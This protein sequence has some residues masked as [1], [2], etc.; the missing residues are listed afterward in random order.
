MRAHL[1]LR[2]TTL[3]GATVAE[4]RA[5]NSVMRGGAELVANL[6]AGK[7]TPITHMVVGTN[8]E[9]EGDQFSTIA[10]ANA[11]VGGEPALTGGTEAPIPP[12]AFVITTDPTHR[13]S[14]V[15]IHATL[16]AASAIGTVR[17]AGLLAR[18]S[19]D[20]ATLYNR[21]TFAPLAKNADHELTMFWE[22]SFPYGDLQWLQ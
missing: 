13:L 12:E 8:D 10:L 4:R 6:F 19:A 7:G 21:V 2:L 3:E 15:R 5:A 17:E 18:A 9:P 22:V 14:T 20:A 11:A 1:L 16:P